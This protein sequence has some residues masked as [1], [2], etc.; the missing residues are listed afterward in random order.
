MPKGSFTS[1][2]RQ[3][4]LRTPIG[5]RDARTGLGY[6]ILNPKNQTPRSLGSIYPYYE[7]E[8]LDP[9]DEEIDQET[10]D[11]ISKKYSKYQPS[12]FSRAAGSDPFYF[13]AGN[14]KLSDCFF[15][16]DDV[17]AEVAS[18]GDSMT[19]VPGKYRGLGGGMGNS[20]ASFPYQGGGGTN[21]KRTGTTYGWSHAPDPIDDEENIS[22]CDESEPIFTL[23]DLAKQKS[24]K[25][26]EEFPR[27]N[28]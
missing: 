3:S 12:D 2:G 18:F 27:S 25:N 9:D 15:R 7:K 6:G 14:T 8:E 23:R 17:L 20:G 11:T 13:T 21:Y 26:G 10:S 28:I 4:T 22:D 1:H 19:G 24:K 5:S 16:T